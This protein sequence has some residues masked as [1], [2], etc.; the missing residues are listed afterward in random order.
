M[1]DPKRQSVTLQ[2]GARLGPY[3]IL[4]LLGA[5]GMGE[6]YRARDTRLA[7]DVALKIL[8]GPTGEDSGRFRRF[9]SEAKAAAALSH[10]NIVAVYDI[11]QEAGTPY[12]V[13]ELVLGGTLTKLLE[14]G[15]L[16][17]KRLLDLAIP[18][19]EA[20]A[21][22]H[23][24]G[25]VHR[26][27]KP[28]NILLSRDGP[29]KVADFGLAKYF[30]PNPSEGSRGTTL[31]DDRTRE[32]MI[33]GTVGY[34]SPEQAQGTT[35]DYRSDQF[36][37]GSVL[38]E[39]ATGRRAFHGKSAVETLAAIINEEPEPIGTLTPNIP[40][41][42]RWIVERCHA[43]DPKH[44]YASTEDLAR[45]LSTVRLHLTE[46][47][48][49]GAMAALRPRRGRLL[50]PLAVV[51]AAFS[52]LLAV[53]VLRLRPP[54]ASLPLKILSSVVVPE[55]FILDPDIGTVALSPEG[56]RLLFCVRGLEEDGRRSIWVRAL[57]EPVP[58]RL[59]AA[60]WGRQPFWSADGR[61]IAYF[62][63]GLEKLVA[64]DSSGGAERTICAASDG[65]GGAWNRDGVILFSPDVDAPLFR[66]SAS[67]GEPAPVTRLD[68]QRHEWSHRWP[69]FL[70]DG[71]HF[72][73]LSLTT[74]IQTGD[75]PDAAIFVGSLDSTNSTQLLRVKSRAIYSPDGYLLWVGA[76]GALMA[77]PFDV[78]RLR[79]T[80]VPVPVAEG[81]FRLSRGRAG[82]SVSRNGILAYEVEPPPKRLAWFDRKGKE[83]D[84]FEPP[85]NPSG[86]RL[87]PDGQKLAALVADS[88]KRNAI[89]IYDLARRAG[90]VITAGS[91][92]HSL[93][94]WSPDG[95]QIAYSSSRAS[96]QEICVRPSSG[97]GSE[98]ILLRSDQ[99]AIPTDW[100][101]DGKTILFDR[102][103]NQ[104]ASGDVWALPLAGDRKPYPVLQT[105][106]DEFGAR[107]SPDG[108]WIVYGSSDGDHNGVYVHS[109]ESPGE[110]KQV[111]TGPGAWNPVWG[112]DG[113]EIFYQDNSDPIMTVDV[114]VQGNQ[115]RLGVPKP[116]FT[117]SAIEG[118]FDVSSDGQR[119]LVSTPGP[120]ANQ[121]ITLV[122]NWAAGLKP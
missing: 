94:V 27:L 116:L 28:D 22:A 95:R 11:G 73:F 74:K 98:E 2:P 33:V 70:P 83:L 55:S 1:S 52:I 88:E 68:P 46:V 92:D 122:H 59:P 109:F 4:S 40:A 101:P 89:W 48:G 105:E 78:R 51:A 31:P 103:K 81:V 25:I 121:T 84:F 91:Y 10:P 65:Y 57:S 86:I 53:G 66:V 23:A 12:I 8:P 45:D 120:K 111:S 56:D 107:F 79:L 63:P 44:R 30:Q 17:V 87:S 69:S 20:F 82:F 9:Q 18:M 6:V 37:F 26:D 13:S 67:G 41:P 72:L 90:S 39:M 77:Q 99:H 62:R 15:P 35:V 58:R 106:L 54:A 71:R 61:S 3:E 14:R 93:P 29:P 80:G 19:A 108:R 24:S 118:G 97:G 7:R 60:D 5:G 47:S 43:K 42:L 75:D 34:M 50:W 38:Y 96:S 115:L 113:R 36:S 49:S 104:K 76:R 64:I 112:R 119:F 85:G 102:W 100:S 32:G 114:T 16:T 110:R 117:W 21:A